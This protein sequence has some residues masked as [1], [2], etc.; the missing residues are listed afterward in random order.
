M[1]ALIC[2]S[3]VYDTVMVLDGKFKH[4]LLTNEELKNRN[5]HFLVPELRRQFGGSAGNIVYNLKKLGAQPLPMATVGVDFNDYAQWLDNQGIK[6]TYVTKI[7]HTYTAH[8]FISLDLDDNQIRAF[9]P[10]AMNYS[11]YNKILE[12]PGVS[13]GTISSENKKG[14]V[15]HAL[16]FVEVGVP[17]IFYPG[18]SITQFDGDDLLKFIEQA[19]WILVTQEEWHRLQRLTGLSPS[20]T[21]R[22]LQ[23]LIITKG[24]HGSV[25]YTRETLYQIPP[26]PAKIV[27]DVAGCEDA[28]CAGLLYGLLKDIDWET[29]GR[30]ATL[31]STIK[32]EHQGAQNHTFSLGE[33][34]LRFKKHFGYTLVI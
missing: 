26:A 4:Y 7:E 14:M 10:G 31:M 1:S 27:I 25:I 17:F 5:I 15:M 12:I 29:T 24:H 33:F 23:A 16:Q 13:V 18:A 8:N 21:A 34:K 9:H 3:L 30:L 22:R 2:G 32:A 28:F 20:Q 6:R 19:T 11:H